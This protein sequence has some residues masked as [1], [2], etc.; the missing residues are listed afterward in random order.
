MSSQE[1]L[2]LHLEKK[3]AKPSCQQSKQLNDNAII[4]V[5]GN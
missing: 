3:H 1:I 5:F 4:R 2:D